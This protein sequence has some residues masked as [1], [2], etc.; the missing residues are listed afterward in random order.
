MSKDAR[1]VALARCLRRAMTRSEAVL[2]SQLRG[3][4]LGGLK[5]RRQHPIGPYVLDFFCF[6]ARLAVEVDGGVHADERAA[7]HDDERDRWLAGQGLRVVR[8]P[9]RLVRDNLDETLR[10]IG[11]AAGMTVA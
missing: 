8:L 3:K 11:E 2:W 6:T 1:T 9:D 10:I 5:F 4:R 7:Q